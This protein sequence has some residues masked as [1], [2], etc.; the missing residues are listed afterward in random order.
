M[1]ENVGHKTVTNVFSVLENYKLMGRSVLIDVY[2]IYDS[3]PSY[4]DGVS[5]TSTVIME[6]LC[7]FDFHLV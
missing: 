6:T 7:R 4:R 1:V 2:Y 3:N 5:L